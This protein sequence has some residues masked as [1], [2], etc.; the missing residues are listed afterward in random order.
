[1]VGVLVV[2]KSLD[3]SL[4]LPLPKLLK[5]SKKHNVF[6]LKPSKA[7]I[8]YLITNRNIHYFNLNPCNID[9]NFRV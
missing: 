6:L 7:S 5:P 3:I 4:Q 1:M 9:Y 2:T 8:A